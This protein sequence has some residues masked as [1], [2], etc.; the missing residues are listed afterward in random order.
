MN[1]KSAR[2]LLAFVGYPEGNPSPVQPLGLTLNHRLPDPAVALGRDNRSV[3]EDLL[4][5]AQVGAV[6]QQGSVHNAGERESF[7]QEFIDQLFGLIWDATLG[8][9][10]DKLATTVF[11]LPLW[12]AVMDRPVLDYSWCLTSRTLHQMASLDYNSF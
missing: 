1:H 7:E 8:W 6:V 3:A 10:S 2:R 9:F 5:A 4:H 12:L 11:T